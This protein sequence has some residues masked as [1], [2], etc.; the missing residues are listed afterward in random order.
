MNNGTFV[1]VWQD[2]LVTERSDARPADANRAAESR[3]VTTVAE[4]K[5]LADP[6][7]QAILAALARDA[8]RELRIL[9]VKELA[10]ELREP[11]TKLYRHVKQLE[12]AGLIRVASTRM[13]RGIQEQRYQ[14]CQGDL[15]IGPGAM[16]EAGAAGDALAVV[17]TT[18]DRYRSRYLAHLAALPESD[19]PIPPDNRS[20]LMIGAA[21]VS[22]AKVK[23]IRDKLRQA[24]AELDV[25][26]T[27]SDG[28]VSVEVLVSF[29][30]PNE[31]PD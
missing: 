6:V 20:M 3:S 26:A 14:A 13:V 29:L 16:L 17:A 9:S 5:A 18:M 12:A 31:P 1:K 21:K 11:K 15:T 27:D 8:P 7:R 30:I 22:P 28:A 19:G 23:A 2:D 10:A 4:L 24:V 25:S